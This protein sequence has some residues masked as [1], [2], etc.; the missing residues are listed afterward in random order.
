MRYT[1]IGNPSFNRFSRSLSDIVRTG[2]QYQTMRE[3]N[4]S[5]TDKNKMFIEHQTC[6]IVEPQIAIN[7]LARHSSFLFKIIQL[8]YE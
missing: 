7:S 8:T 3:S 1:L 2:L 4:I 6:K 5:K